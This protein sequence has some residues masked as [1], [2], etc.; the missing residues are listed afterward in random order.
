MSRVKFEDLLRR[1][2][3]RVDFSVVCASEELD[4]EG[5]LSFASSVWQFVQEEEGHQH[6]GR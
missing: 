3:R 2:R 4:W 1:E 5:V 6:A